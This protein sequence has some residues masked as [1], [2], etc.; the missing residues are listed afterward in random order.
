MCCTTLAATGKRAVGNMYVWV[1]MDGLAEAAAQSKDSIAQPEEHG[2]A[3]A[4]V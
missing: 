1:R 2:V 3:C 4:S